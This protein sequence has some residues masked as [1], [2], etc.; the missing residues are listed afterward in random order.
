M[1]LSQ[2][3]L[4]YIFCI[5]LFSVA[6]LKMNEILKELFLADNKL[7][8]SDG[9]QIG[10]LLKYNHTLELLDLR[11][12]HLQVRKYESLFNIYLNAYWI[13]VVLPLNDKHI[14]KQLF[15]VWIWL[16][17]LIHYFN[18]KKIINTKSRYIKSLYKHLNTEIWI[19]TCL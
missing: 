6:A 12:N 2:Y 16:K 9:I 8:P 7:M 5:Y 17:S 10:S 1:L 4:P 15:S 19:C 11:N 14:V 13:I 3:C 18:S